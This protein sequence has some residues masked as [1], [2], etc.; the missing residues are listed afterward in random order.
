MKAILSVSMSSR[1]EKA[2]SVVVTPADILPS[3]TG[4]KSSESIETSEARRARRMWSMQAFLA[5]S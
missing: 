3:S 5:I 1:A 2:A 4:E